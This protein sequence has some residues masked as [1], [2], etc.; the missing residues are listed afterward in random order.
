MLLQPLQGSWVKRATETL[1]ETLPA[2][3]QREDKQA[4]TIKHLQNRI[5][6]MKGAGRSQGKQVAPK[7]K[8]K[9]AG[10]GRSQIKM[11][12]ELVD[13]GDCAARDENGEALCFKFQL[14]GCDQ[15]APGEKCPK[16]WHKCAKVGCN[17][18]HGRRSHA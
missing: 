6:N 12:R 14:G 10:K 2:K 17:G 8:A 1:P 9:A 15:G 5:N 4:E 11:P 7:G 16:G 18:H 13:F 3:R